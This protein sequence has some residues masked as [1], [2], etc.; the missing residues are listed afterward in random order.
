MNRS[1]IKALQDRLQSRQP[2]SIKAELPDIFGGIALV[3]FFLFI[4]FI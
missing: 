1:E 4:L 2:Q 3:L